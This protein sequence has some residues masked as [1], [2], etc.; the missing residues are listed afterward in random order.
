MIVHDEDFGTSLVVEV[1]QLAGNLGHFEFRRGSLSPLT[2]YGRAEPAA[3]GR[4]PAVQLG[5]QLT[6]GRFSSVVVSGRPDA[7]LR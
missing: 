3:A 5:C 7:D 1:S 6:G 2:T 4:Y